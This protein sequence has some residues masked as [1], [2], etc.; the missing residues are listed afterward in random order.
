MK[1]N[2]P[3][4]THWLHKGRHVY[5]MVYVTAQLQLK[6]PIFI[7]KWKPVTHYLV[8]IFCTYILLCFI[9]SLMHYLWER[10]SVTVCVLYLYTVIFL[11]D[12]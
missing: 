10:I 5:M 6:M 1:P 2:P 8:P 12:K 9:S 3:M 4:I 11:Y 7:R